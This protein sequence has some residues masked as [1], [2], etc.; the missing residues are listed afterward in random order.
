MPYT[1]NI[2][3][4]PSL[5]DEMEDFW[6]TQAKKIVKQI[7]TF[8]DAG[9]FSGINHIDAICFL[10]QAGV[11]ALTRVQTYVFRKIIL[12]F[13]EDVKKNISVMFTFADGRKPEAL[14]SFTQAGLL[15][16]EVKY[17]KFNNSALFVD[18]VQHSDDGDFDRL[19]WSLG[20]KGFEKFFKSFNELESKSLAL[21]ME[22]C[23]W[24]ET[25]ALK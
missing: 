21:T 20:I 10:A 14:S 12:M 7:H 17:L 25:C 11:P 23:D 16:N 22:E 8:F 3:D 9:G 15:D 4:T 2:V 24:D 1:L 18:N 13:G 6:L 5:V 19:F